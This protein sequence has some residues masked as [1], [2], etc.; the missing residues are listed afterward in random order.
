MNL[1]GG[2][3]AL[4]VA[5]IIYVCGRGLNRFLISRGLKK[6]QMR[7]VVVPLV[8]IALLSYFSLRVW[9]IF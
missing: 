9:K 2:L 7:W 5:L 4:V 8:A 1:R 6:N 3:E